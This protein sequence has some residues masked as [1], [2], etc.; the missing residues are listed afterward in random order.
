MSNLYFTGQVSQV[1]LAFTGDG[2][3]S[4]IVI[5]G[6]VAAAGPQGI[7]GI[8]GPAGTTDHLLLSNIGTN[9]HAQIDTALT[10]QAA[11][12]SAN[13][14]AIAGK[15]ATSHT[16]AESD[17]TNL[18]SDLAL[19][20]PLASPALTGT[21]TTPTATSGTNTTQIAST[22]FVKTAVDNVIASAPGA[23]DTLNELAA[24]L[25][26][27]A[28]FATT[29][30]NS[31]ATKASLTGTETLTNKT[32]SGASNTLSNIPESAVTNLT[33]DLAAKSSK[34]FAIALAVAL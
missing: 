19:K 13:T 31:L 21:P 30:T 29:V 4:Q 11:L 32:I 1:P 33:T 34:A 5:T 15:A 28:S 20:A 8:Q 26:N 6:S 25:G 16:H 3:A 2:Q 14:T 12:I 27:D 24:A 7:Q 9:T 10:T 22:A 17:V 23:L 18:T